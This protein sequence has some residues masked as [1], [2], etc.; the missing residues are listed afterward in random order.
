LYPEPITEQG[1][2][3]SHRFAMESLR[4]RSPVSG[5]SL[6]MDNETPVE[7]VIP[8]RKGPFQSH[9]LEN[10]NLMSRILAELEEPTSIQPPAIS[11]TDIDDNTGNAPLVN[12]GGIFSAFFRTDTSSSSRSITESTLERSC[13]D[14]PA[15]KQMMWIIDNQL[16]QS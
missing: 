15:M 3:K 5:S 4:P 2:R 16:P 13:F 1:I 11:T 14:S 8:S 9:G 7:E 12:D 10:V 6:S